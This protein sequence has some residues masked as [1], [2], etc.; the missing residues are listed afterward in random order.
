MKDK[1]HLSVNE[2]AEK[3]DKHPNTVRN[4]IKNGIIK[5]FRLGRSRKASYRI[6]LTEIERMI[7]VDLCE[8]VEK[9]A[10][11]Q[12]NENNQEG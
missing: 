11:Q 3:I 12:M 8:V 2:F 10:I 6:P 7:Y 9:K 5:A 4:A 1:E